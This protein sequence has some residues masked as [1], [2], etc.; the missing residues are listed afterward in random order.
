MPEASSGRG[1][2]NANFQICS[3]TPTGTVHLSL[4][5]C[6]KTRYNFCVQPIEQCKAV[7]RGNKHALSAGP[8]TEDSV[9]GLSVNCQT[10][11]P[12]PRN[13]SLFLWLPVQTQRETHHFHCICNCQVVLPGKEARKG[14]ACWNARREQNYKEVEILQQ[15]NL[16]LA[17]TRGYYYSLYS[18]QKCA[19]G[20]PKS[21]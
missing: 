6:R 19:V 10:M 18:V 13:G 9:P 15:P 8:H 7:L 1:L 20:L 3:Q 4:P 5:D 16:H 2:F 12:R 14:Q 11:N 21:C 17:C